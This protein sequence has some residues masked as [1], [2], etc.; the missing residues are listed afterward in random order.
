VQN[1]TSEQQ[2]FLKETERVDLEETEE[3]QKCAD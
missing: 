2:Q 3:E 1:E